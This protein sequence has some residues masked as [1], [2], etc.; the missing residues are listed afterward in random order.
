MNYGKMIILIRGKLNITQEELAK[1]LNISFAT[2][3]RWENNHTVPSK[4]YICILEEI[5]KEHSIQWSV[6]K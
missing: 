4:R 2:V 1:K 5:C 6:E 3:N